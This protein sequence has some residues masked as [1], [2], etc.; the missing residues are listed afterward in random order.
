MGTLPLQGGGE[1]EYRSNTLKPFILHF[2]TEDTPRIEHAKSVGLIA[3]KVDM[4][5]PLLFVPL[6]GNN[7]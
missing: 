4:L 3:K 5:G 7:L 1:I 6:V 2:Y